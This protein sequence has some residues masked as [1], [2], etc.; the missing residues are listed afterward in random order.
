[1]LNWKN[2]TLDNSSNLSKEATDV[3]LNLGAFYKLVK[4][5]FPKYYLKFQLYDQK[6]KREG[7]QTT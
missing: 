7:K 6:K 2:N 1:M 3:E 4:H 5:S